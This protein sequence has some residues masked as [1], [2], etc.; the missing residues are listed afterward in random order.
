M[1]SSLFTQQ[2]KEGN[3][4]MSIS[5]EILDELISDAKTAHDV[6]GSALPTSMYS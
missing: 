6:F 1:L 4:H 3:L 5:N 2:V